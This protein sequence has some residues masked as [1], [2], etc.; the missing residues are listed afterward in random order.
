[1]LNQGQSSKKPLVDNGAKQGL[2]SAVHQRRIRIACKMSAPGMFIAMSSLLT[3]QR[4][5]AESER[6]EDVMKKVY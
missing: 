6:V 1:M 5:P 3:V 4:C 2:L